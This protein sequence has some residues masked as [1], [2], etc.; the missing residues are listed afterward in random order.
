[1][2]AATP[3]YWDPSGAATAA[4]GSGTWDATTAEWRSGSPTGPLVAWANAGDANGPYQAVFSAGSGTVTLGVGV[5]ASSVSFTASGYTLSGANALTLA[6]GTGQVDVASGSTE[7]IA[8]PV[9][10]TV[11]LT[12]TSAGKLTLSGSNTYS[13]G[14][15]LAAGTLDVT[16]DAALGAVPSSTSTNITFSG[17]A[18]LQAGAASVSLAGQR[19][20]SIAAGVTA[21]LDTQS[22][23]LTVNG[24]IS[25][26][27]STGV[28]S[29]GGTAGTLVLAGS[30]SFV[31]GT[32]VSMG[33]GTNV[34]AGT[35]EL[36]NGGAL[37]TNAITV[38][39]HNVTNNAAATL[40]LAGGVTVGSNVTYLVGG[41]QPSYNDELD[42]VGGNNVFNGTFD[43]DNTG[44]NYAVQSTSGTLTFNGTVTIGFSPS[45]ARQLVFQG[46]ANGVVGVTIA[47]DIAPVFAGPGTWTVNAT[48]TYYGATTVNGGTLS[49]NV[50]QPQY[51][52]LYSIWNNGSITVN[53]GGTLLANNINALTG[54]GN[55]TTSVVVNAGGTL[56]NR[57][58]YTNHLVNLTLAG[59][60][61]ASAAGSA[62]YAGFDVQPGDVVNV[63]AN[64][65]ITGPSLAMEAGAS[66][67][68]AA[69]DTLQVTGSIV[70]TGVTSGF[71]Q[72]TKT[73]PGTMVLA[74][75]NT[76]AGAITVD[77]GTLAIGAGGVAV[78]GTLDLAGGTLSDAGP[79]YVG[80][81]STGS[82]S[83]V[84]TGGTATVAGNLIVGMGAPGTVAVSGGTLAVAANAYVGY[85]ANGTLAISGT[86]TVTDA[87]TLYV[88]GDGVAGDPAGVG[89]VDLS[90][91][92]SLTTQQTYVGYSGPA[93]FD[94]TGGTDTAQTLVLD[95]PSGRTATYQVTGGTVAV[96]VALDA[97]AP[98]AAGPGTVNEGATYTLGL[99][100]TTSTNH[101]AINW[102]DGS[103]PQT[104]T[105][106]SATHAYGT[107]G[108]YTVTAT[109]YDGSGTASP[110]T[111]IPVLVNDV[112][113]TVLIGGQTSTS[114]NPVYL[115]GRA[116][117]AI[118]LS[119]T[120]TDPG[121]TET[122]TALVNWGDGTSS[123]ATVTESGGTG[124]ITASHVYRLYGPLHAG[125]TVTD[126]GG[127]TVSVPFAVEVAYVVPTLSISTTTNVVTNVI[128]PVTLTL[129]DAGPEAA[130]TID[131]W[132]VSW[133][134]G[135]A[136]QTITSPANTTNPA[137]AVWTVTHTYATAGSYT[138]TATATDIGGD[139]ATN[140]VTFTVGAAVPA[141]A[142]GL[143]ATG[144]VRDGVTLN[145]TDNSNNETGFKVLRSSDGG[146]SYT[147][148]K[149]TAAN[150]VSYTDDAVTAGATY[151]YEVVATNAAGDA[152]AD[153]LNSFTVLLPPPTVSPLTVSSA[154]AGSDVTITAIASPY[155]N[156]GDALAYQWTLVDLAAT[157][158][159]VTETTSGPSLTYPL[160]TGTVG[161]W[162][163][164][165]AVT[166]GAADAPTTV[167][168]QFVV[169]APAPLTI[170]G[171]TLLDAGGTGN[172]S[173]TGTATNNVTWTVT[174]SA[175]GVVATGLGEQFSYTPTDSGDYTIAAQGA[176]SGGNVSTASVALAVTHLDPT[177]TI[178]GPAVGFVGK[179][180]TFGSQVTQAAGADDVLSYAW[181]LLNADGSPATVPTGTEPA[182]QS[183]YAVPGGL[184]AGSYA[185]QLTVTDTY[186]G[187][188]VPVRQTFDFTVLADPTGSG[189]FSWGTAA[190]SN[191]LASDD[192]YTDGFSET[193]AYPDA[194]AIAIQPDGKILVA[195]LG[196]PQ[197]LGDGDLEDP[198]DTTTG[199]IARFNADLTVDTS[200]GS[201]HTGLVPVDFSGDGVGNISNVYGMAINPA[202]GDVVVVGDT[203]P[204]SIVA[205]SPYLNEPTALA[206]AEY[207]TSS[208]IAADG[209]MVLAG[210]PDPAFDGGD[211]FTLAN[212]STASIGTQV[213]VLSDGDIVVA[214]AAATVS[215]SAAV[216]ARDNEL[217]FDGGSF[218]VPDFVA[219]ELT[220]AGQ[221]DTSFNGIGE[222]AHPGYAEQADV[223][224]FSSYEPFASGP[225][226]TED[227]GGYMADVHSLTVLKNSDGTVTGFLLAG[228]VSRPILAGGDVA[229]DVGIALVRYAADG[230]LD[231]SFGDGGS[232]FTTSADFNHL[233][234]GT[235]N[236]AGEAVAMSVE[237]TS[238][239]GFLVA[240]F[241][242][243]SPN[244]FDYT[245]TEYG[246]HVILACYNADGSIDTSY[247]DGGIINT[248][249]AYQGA[250]AVTNAAGVSDGVMGDDP[251]RPLG[252]TDPVS[253]DLAYEMGSELAF[254]ADGTLLLSSVS[255]ES[256]WALTEIDPAT[257]STASNFGDDGVLNVP[258]DE[259]Q[260]QGDS[261]A[262]LQ[263]S[264]VLITGGQVL[265]AGDVG[266]FYR[267][268][269]GGWTSD[270]TGLN[271]ES[272]WCPESPL[273]VRYDT[274]VAPAASDLA[275]SATSAGAVNLTWT[276][277]GYGQDGFS[278]SRSTS[279]G[280]PW[281]LLA[282]VGPDQD[283]YTDATVA[284]GTTYVYQVVPYYTDGSGAQ[285][286]GT[287]SNTASVLTPPASD[288]GYALQE[289]LE[290][291]VT[292]TVVTSS[293]PLAAGQTYLIVATG[294]FGLQSGYA[295]DAG[296]WY[297]TTDPDAYGTSF[298]G[299]TYGVALGDA[300]NPSALAVSNWGLW[301]ATDHSYTLAYAGDGNALSF[302]FDAAA[303]P[304]AS[305][306]EPIQVEIYALHPATPPSQSPPST[307]TGEPT[308]AIT[309][310]GADGNTVPQLLSVAG[311]VD[312]QAVAADG[313]AVP[314]DLWLVAPNGDQQ[315]LQSSTTFTGSVTGGLTDVVTLHP[316]SYAGGVYHLL[317]VSAL[318]APGVN[319]SITVAVALEPP[320]LRFTAPAAEVGGVAPVVSSNDPV[321]VLVGD[322]QGT[323]VPWQLRLAS[324]SGAATVLASGIASAGEMP[325]SGQQ[326]ATLD[327][328]LYPNG[329]YTL[330]L[331]TT[332]ADG[333]DNV[334]YS[335]PVSIETVAKVG[336]L[337][338]PVTDATVQTGAGS[339]TV[340]RTYDS[341]LVNQPDGLPGFGP[342]WSFDLIDSQL[343][344]TARADTNDPSATTPVLRAGDLV[345]LTAPDGGRQVFE[346]API[347]FNESNAYAGNPAGT[348]YQ[349]TFIALDGSGAKLTLPGTPV[350]LAYD[351]VDD[352][353]VQ[354]TLESDI[355]FHDVG[356]N[357][358]RPE[359][360]NQYQLTL[361]DGTSYVIN[362]T[363]G[364]IE[365]TT[366]ASGTTTTYT[367]SGS[368]I[369]ATQMV[370]GN[371]VTLLT[372]H[373]N[374]SNEITSVDV[375]GQASATYTYAA[376][377]LVA[378]TNQA[379]TTTAYAYNFSGNDHY[380][381]GVTN[382][383]GAA[384]LQVQ[385]S[386][387]TD[388]L[389]AIVDAAG[390][391]VP[392]STAPLGTDEVVQ[393]V[394]DQAGDVTRDVYGEKYGTLDRTIQTVTSGNAV[395]DY[396]VTVTGFSYVTDDAGDM[397]SLYP[398]GIQVL[399]GIQTYPAF[400][401]AANTEGMQYSQQPDPNS[402]TK[403]VLYNT[404]D[405]PDDPASLQLQSTSERLTA[406]GE[407]QTTLFSDFA[408]VNSTTGAAKPKVTT[409]ELQTP[410][411]NSVTGYD[412]QVQSTTY[413]DYDG[414]GNPTYA[415]TVVGRNVAGDPAATPTLGAGGFPTLLYVT[416]A[417]TPTT[418]AWEQSSGGY[419]GSVAGVTLT[420]VDTSLAAR[421]AGATPVLG[422]A[423][424]LTLSDTTYYGNHDLVG[425]LA[426]QA[427]DGTPEG[428]QL[429][430]AAL[431]ASGTFVDQTTGQP[432][433]GTTAVSI[434]VPGWVA[435]GTYTDYDGNGFVSDTR[436]VT[437]TIDPDGTVENIA[438]LATTSRQ[439]N[440]D[441]GD[442]ALNAA[443]TAYVPE[444]GAAY[445]APEY[446]FDANG[447][448]TFYAY[449]P[450]G[451][452]ILQYVYKQWTNSSG[453]L[454]D[455][456]VGT[457]SA[458][459][460][461]GRLTDTYSATY[462]DPTAN[463]TQSIAGQ[464]H[465]LPVVDN[466]A[467]VPTV[468]T[469]SAD[470]TYVTVYQAP[471][472]T[473]HVDYNSLGQKADTFDQY[474]GET[475]YTYDANGNVIRTVNPDGTET[476][477]VYDALNRVIWQTSSYVPGAAGAATAA[478]PGLTTHT[479]YNPLGQ[480]TETDQYAGTLITITSKQLGS[481]VTPT[482]VLTT[483]G[484]LVSK[485][486][487]AYD[488]QGNAIETT[489]ANGL[490]TGSIYTPDGQVL[491]TGPLT[492][493]APTDGHTVT[494]AD[495]VST[496]A[497]TTADFSSYSE[498]DPV[499]FDSTLGLFYTRSVD[500]DGNATDTYAD[501]QGRTVRTVYADGSFT[502]TLYSVGG[503]PV[504]VDQEGDAVPTPT[505]WTGIAGGGYEEVTIGQR[506]ST[507]PVDDQHPLPVTYDLYNAA[508]EL[509]DV[510]LPPVQ[511]AGPNSQ[512]GQTLVNPH[513]HYGYDTAGNETAQVSGD[514]N[515]ASP[516]PSA[517][518]AAYTSTW[519]YDQN[520]NQVRQQLPDGEQESW[521]Y[522]A[523]GQVATATDFDGNTATYTYANDYSTPGT[524]AGDPL[525]VTYAGAPGSGK[526]NQAVT[527]TY[528]DLNR[529]QSVT[530][531]S[532]KTTDSY[533]AEGDLVEEDT[534]EGTIHYVF[535]PAT[536]NHTET[537]TAY[538]DTLY[539]Y[540]AE[541]RLASVTV[542]ELNGQTL[543]T[544]LVTTYTYDDAGNKLTETLPD[545]EV[546][547]YTYDALNRLTGLTEV[548]GD[549]TLFSQTYVLNSDGTRASSHAV[550]AQPLSAGGGTVTTDSAWTYDA[551]GRLTI[552]AVTSSDGQGYTTTYSYD[553]DN[554]RTLSVHTGPGDGADETIT[555]AYNGDDELTGQT[556][557]LSGTTTNGY[558]SNGSLTTST[559]NGTTTAYT[560]DARNKL[561][562]YAVGGATLATYVY[563]DAG[564]RVAETVAS[565]G[566][567]TTTRYL[568][569]TQNPNGYDETI[570]QRA[571]SISAPSLTYVLGDRVLAQANSTGQIS[572]LLVDGHG[573]TQAMTSSTGAVISTY[574]Y[575]AFGAA[576]NFT[577]VS[578]GTVFLFGGDAVYD[579]ASGMYF[580]GDGVRD[581]RV[582]DFVQRD[583]LGYSVK[584]NPVSIN[585]YLYADAS[586]LV[587]C[588]PSGHSVFDEGEEEEAEYDD[589]A[590]RAG[591]TA[592]DDIE[593]DIGSFEANESLEFDDDEL[594]EEGGFSLPDR[595]G[596][597]LDY[598]TYPDE[599]VGLGYGGKYNSGAPNVDH[600][601]SRAIGR[602]LGIPSDK[603]Q[604]LTAL[605]NARKGGIEGDLVSTIFSYFREG[606]DEGEITYVLGEEIASLG[607]SGFEIPV[608][609][610]L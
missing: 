444:K 141:P 401:V 277:T 547:T 93:T 352:E 211:A 542:T 405:N 212:A 49:L 361:A 531:A 603:L 91:N 56:A 267:D 64:S 138:V 455:G 165:L 83:Y 324:E 78:A 50:A 92:G 103:A 597:Q 31:G 510:W 425:T 194:Q 325:A 363:T 451:H 182:I 27:A 368:T 203:A 519:A 337:T 431:L 312:V 399:Q 109:A 12:K 118:S 476:L 304:G 247:A 231:T 567:T 129:H 156:N 565:G 253:L 583:S 526:A 574:R 504:S 316:A 533:D 505:G 155:Q 255:D 437:A 391:A 489:A 115:S 468:D 548:Q 441:G 163:V 4:G 515:E 544:P 432:S 343:T 322:A 523:Y 580:H 117:Q 514:G 393:T 457:T 460:S 208:K 89:T 159:T 308:L 359:F 378:V 119:A 331:V 483:A 63:T 11:G 330:Q 496:Q 481:S 281:T 88:S 207:T 536:G 321:D 278:V 594:D 538:T 181:A 560:Y 509:T 53:S 364:Q 59:G 419:T 434:A 123:T 39:A 305:G 360:G 554:N 269:L 503:T 423:W 34:G 58:G 507:D 90:G 223:S 607:S 568:T 581:T 520:G 487:T 512:T 338:L 241:A 185:M 38:D 134:D 295:A 342:G 246:Q 573:N 121:A 495:G 82:S 99:F 387:T 418:L 397:S 303:Y 298:A 170:S 384:V 341:N 545:G 122:H 578:A 242:G 197:S 462:A 294:T 75:S 22:N 380:L 195:G 313:T 180:L 557:S 433:T 317:L 479:V 220:S 5:T 351:P 415:L 386:P 1:M 21:T 543:A 610:L 470:A 426:A 25:N 237:L 166:D 320:V 488:A 100:G 80:S 446:T 113:A 452:T 97:Y 448:E 177:V 382:G 210:E 213:A 541:G 598:Q 412:D 252:D 564:D 461:A 439:V 206:V 344:T 521:T 319:D 175:A 30:D 606:M 492:A 10:G 142:S 256:T 72:I 249:V 215:T 235:P 169:V 184:A 144:N 562:G 549:T 358:A 191:M 71:A 293:L 19:G 128:Q 561:V 221:L 28:L 314:W 450:A 16:S 372:A 68:V 46:A 357:P 229:E 274:A 518:A 329:S 126:S 261:D 24:P 107:A 168:Q 445:G 571:S 394:V 347:P 604:I 494:I 422:D 149:T 87:N 427:F 477:S 453:Q 301:D 60:T 2:M 151:S 522:N 592:E 475:T 42:S 346:F 449:D 236:P 65:T 174:N 596:G 7:T 458:Y 407:L 511:D 502:E 251:I 276:N 555:Y 201:A 112:G 257:G 454:V 599:D 240:G 490:R 334:A 243:T 424:T 226:P 497:F 154:V 263:Q 81:S 500:Q 591:D 17:T 486:T 517:T 586:P 404:S 395:A 535:D 539:G 153:V 114:S 577:A 605:M 287:A 572:Y 148:L 179:S 585:A 602:L 178:S 480:V 374:G 8:A 366:D 575:D 43:I 550:Q 524:D 192:A 350:Q 595:Q 333:A 275:A 73:G 262:F 285:Q 158:N 482:A 311:E 409:V 282:D 588:D 406:G 355:A 402:W 95:G 609:L 416:L 258:T 516:D 485:T 332:Y 234:D 608:G 506:K 398:S 18:S 300:T 239:Q 289:T 224:G 283:D 250:D 20:I 558:D 379:G 26:A 466:A 408:I 66:F 309:V 348:I 225:A 553:L 238:D 383:A 478:D 534:P 413:D 245:D 375:P 116:G 171:P 40:L 552:E 200:F 218:N 356:F 428:L 336:N 306:V 86:G 318:P 307:P 150:V 529:Q 157:S 96:G 435:T 266:D 268:T 556:S 279:P 569:D 473:Q 228:E 131:H 94:Q 498:T 290:V 167:T 540:D 472:D 104:V 110:A 105:S 233:S 47:G 67:Q 463:T 214:G 69:G 271:D 187:T 546:T 15:T 23:T 106:S 74:G 162:S 216:T 133:G 389:S 124:T 3:L 373:L 183:T 327:P 52:T 310:P 576:L 189:G 259:I 465:I 173:V 421:A 587:F 280:G 447:Q 345:S 44:G 288:A 493:A 353:Y 392:V 265:V 54:Y 147:L 196:L 590:K 438:T 315:L 527:Y 442:Y 469:N 260:Y 443:G 264:A 145:W 36:A 296:H 77:A 563:D 219:I 349:A 176:D 326:V 584:S 371:S 198:N 297:S 474:H 248:S 55:N 367:I 6:G 440:Y 390:V 302:Q 376:G 13:G 127:A 76:F 370:G 193:G 292:G 204:T 146:A 566:T 286:L 551:D 600:V 188:S 139:H 414:K 143:T 32:T 41:H 98:T 513:W 152:A 186:D 508:G 464:A 291:P 537:Y 62:A 499:Q 582:F 420:L 430:T 140:S 365:S 381:T 501:S 570:E 530:D 202:N 601:V 589:A 354:V 101:W 340:S 254:Q 61:L 37:G 388:Q 532:G 33:G 377:N 70:S 57:A 471:L 111:T 108:S 323:P 102:G 335:E 84:Q 132:T 130:S 85:S 410:D 199:W 29:K 403:Q 125:L 48:Q 79:L 190:T 172:Y 209:Q 385:Y 45:S 222:T 396:I 14:T 491:Y 299:V 120:F 429:C 484:T 328:A 137:D 400:E 35:L 135:S 411:A 205:G 525:N 467:G 459:D 272:L 161:N 436:S 136:P 284:P 559:S 227:D 51:G 164:T 417:G 339:V 270:N 456:W 9:A 160:P 230:T 232:V 579:P 528:D 369:T 593:E 217:G 362:A 273:L 244:E